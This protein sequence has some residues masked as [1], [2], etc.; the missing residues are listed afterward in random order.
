MA[1]KTFDPKQV[2]ITFGTLVLSGFAEDSMITLEPVEKLSDAVVGMDG[3][4][5][6]IIK[7][8]RN[9]TAK[10]KL[11]A[12]SESHK[13]MMAQTFIGGLFQVNTFPFSL[14]SIATNESISSAAAY[15]EQEPTVEMSGAGDAREWSLYL[16]D[17]DIVPLGV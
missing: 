5:Q 8:N 11:L 9:Y 14:T 2:V 17:V 1:L 13:N 15:V 4:T 3:Q 16:V 7:N 12:T 10:V 6:R